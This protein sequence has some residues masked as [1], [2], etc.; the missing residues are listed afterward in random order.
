MKLP[1]GAPGSSAESAYPERIRG[2]DAPTA[3]FKGLHQKVLT[4]RG[5]E[6]F[7]GRPFE[8]FAQ[9]VLTP[10]VRAIKKKIR[11]DTY[12]LCHCGSGKKFK[13]CCQPIHESLAQAFQLDE[14]GQHDAALRLM[15]DLLANNA[16]NPE[17]HGRYAQLLFQNDRAAEAETALEEAF[18]L[19]PNYAFGFVLRAR[20]RLYEGE[21]PGALMLL[22]KAVELYHPDAHAIL[23]QVYVDI[24]ECEMRLNHPIAARAAVELALRHDPS[25]ESLRTAMSTVFGDATP[26][27]PPSARKAYSFLPNQSADPARQS[28]WKQAL[29]ASTKLS[30]G[31]K[32]FA[33]LVASD[34]QD[35][36][37]WF[38]LALCQA[39]LGNNLASQESLEKYTELETDDAQAA[40]AWHLAEVLRSGQGMEDHADYVEHS[41]TFALQD[42]QG[43]VNLLSELEQK[44]KLAGIRINREEGV[45]TAMLLQDPPPALTPELA[46][47]QCA[48]LGAFLILMGNVVRLWHVRRETV[49]K[50]AEELQSQMRTGA[51]QP[52][53]SRGP[54]KFQDVLAE[55]LAFPR[56]A[57]TPEQARE[58]MQP[59]IQ[60]FFEGEW[61]HRPLKATKGTPPID[62]VGHPVYRRR[63]LGAIRFLEEIGE[64][65]RLPYDFNSLRHKLGLAPGASIAEGKPKD[66]DELSAAELAQLNPGELDVEQ[67]EKAFHA[68]LRLDARDL[69]G[70]FASQL[71]E[72]PADSAKPD[73]WPFFQHLIQNATQNGNHA[74]ALD[75]INEGEKQDCEGNEGRRRN[76]YELRRAQVL[77]RSGDFPQAEEVFDRLI[78]R[79]PTEMKYRITACETMLSAKQ[80]AKAKKFAEAGLNEAKQK[81]LRDLEGAFGEMLDQAKRYGG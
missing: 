61:L 42:P 33:A 30:E 56:S 1:Q 14:E 71:I 40:E 37:A 68:A 46:A 17:V 25:N 3:G 78:A 45:L 28:Q 39:W 64:M 49:E 15:T 70:Q 4:K 73:R 21:V 26:N 11:M 76:D 13:W 74:T 6:P 52:F 57:T 72:Q 58:L 7:P 9:R 47:K 23:T 35:K 34:P 16:S 62:A 10:L 69:A 55:V 36:A 50:S 53:P 24:F 59:A 80:G 66:L 54:V 2:L 18:K 20:F 27:L 29:A 77:A 48:S 22:R 51:S 60:K 63:L 8:C 31:L 32:A 38:N 65:I 43:F 75:F 5:Q 41:I 12:E 81:N 19:Q 44:G 67:L 79:V